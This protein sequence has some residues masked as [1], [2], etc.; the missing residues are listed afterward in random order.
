VNYTAQAKNICTSIVN[1]AKGNSAGRIFLAGNSVNTSTKYS[2]MVGLNNGG[3]YCYGSGGISEG[4]Y[5]GAAPN[6]PYGVGCYYN[7]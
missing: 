6:P 7:P 5:G 4:L 1:N 2:I 3:Y